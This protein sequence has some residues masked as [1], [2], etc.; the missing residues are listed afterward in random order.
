MNYYPAMPVCLNADV[1]RIATWHQYHKTLLPQTR[2]QTS[3]APGT[4]VSICL[5]SIRLTRKNFNSIIRHKRINGYQ[6]KLHIK[7]VWDW[8]DNT[9]NTINWHNSDQHFKAPA[10]PISVWVQWTKLIPRWQP[11]VGAQQLWDAKV[12][13]PHQYE[14]RSAILATHNAPNCFWI[15]YISCKAY[16]QPPLLAQ[17]FLSSVLLNFIGTALKVR[18]EPEALTS[19]PIPLM[20]LLFLLYTF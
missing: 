2:Q 4:A 7:K 10:A 18:S 16:Q 8:D 11:P 20:L 12:K 19:Y 17:L 5:G 14:S 3:H 15:I 9:C 6:A 13:D 1:D